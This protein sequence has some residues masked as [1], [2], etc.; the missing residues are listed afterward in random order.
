MK[1]MKFKV[2]IAFFSLICLFCLTSSIVA[3]G[4]QSSKKYVTMRTFESNGPDHQIVIAYEDGSVEQID[5]IRP[6]KIVDFVANLKKINETINNLASKG[7]ELVS[8]SGTDVQTTTY[9][10]VKK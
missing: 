2:R 3:S 1:T 7:Y 5:L 9:V 10:F 8:T 4:Q 6:Y